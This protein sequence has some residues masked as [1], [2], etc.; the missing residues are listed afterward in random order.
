VL[1]EHS[2]WV[3]PLN[4][5]SGFDIKYKFLNFYQLWTNLL[6]FL[7][8]FIYLFIYLLTYLVT[9]LQIFLLIYLFTKLFYLFV[10]YV[11]SRNEL[12]IVNFGFIG[13]DISVRCVWNNAIIFKGRADFSTKDFI[14][15]VHKYISPPMCYLIK[16]MSG[17]QLD[18]Y[19]VVLHIKSD[20]QIPQPLKHSN[21]HNS[22]ILWALELILVSLS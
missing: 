2:V 22:S 21:R 18:V 14:Y 9:Y 19:I 15:N 16:W 17:R 11:I 10:C 6:Y 1:I 4:W 13:M 8:L 3:E 5:N 7:C 20:R 12:S